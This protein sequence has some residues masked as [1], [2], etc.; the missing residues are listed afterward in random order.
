M[1]PSGD[2]RAELFLKRLT[3]GSGVLLLTPELGPDVPISGD[4]AVCAR[5]LRPWDLGE[6][7]G[8]STTRGFSIGAPLARIVARGYGQQVLVALRQ[9]PAWLLRSLLWPHSVL[10]LLVAGDGAAAKAHLA[11]A[12]RS[13]LSAIADWE[14]AGVYWAT[15][16][17]D[18]QMACDC[19]EKAAASQG[20]NLD[21]DQ[22]CMAWDW[23]RLCGDQDRA[24]S[25]LYAAMNAGPASGTIDALAWHPLVTHADAWMT[26]F[27]REDWAAQYLEYASAAAASGG[28]AGLFP[29]ATAW[30]QILGNERRAAALAEQGMR[31][32]GESIR[33][34]L[35]YWHC[36]ANDREKAMECLWVKEWPN[37][38]SPRFRL[39]LAQC[40]VMFKGFDGEEDCRCHAQG[41]IKEASAEELTDITT[42]CAAAKLWSSVAG[43]G[44]ED[45]LAAA[46]AQAKE[47]CDLLEIADTWR[48]LAH[49]SAEMRL[50]RAHQVLEHAEEIAD[51]AIDYSLC[52]HSWRTVVGDLGNTERCLAK[53]E[54]W[55]CEPQ[56]MSL[57]AQ[58]WVK[59]LGRPDEARRLVLEKSQTILRQER[60]RCD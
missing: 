59:L 9:A 26:L 33:C 11:D 41:L 32:K 5:F 36:V 14:A 56:D 7:I 23:L 18:R 22:A 24:L 12:R 28:G 19:F 43:A 42:Q 46:E 13:T 30:M 31:S 53:G 49:V 16:F 44:A 15:F 8:H 25:C 34:A 47:S 35:L 40:T 38:R 54:A 10:S 51:N 55:A 48:R 52:A 27:D 21:A 45:M 57:L 2:Q 50:A 29:T 3:G 1:T 6:H 20:P 60:A 37:C 17:Q 4:L 39:S 58:G